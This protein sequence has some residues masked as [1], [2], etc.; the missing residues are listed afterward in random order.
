MIVCFLYK[1]PKEEI[2]KDDDHEQMNMMKTYYSYTVH[3]ILKD[4]TY[5]R[6]VRCNNELGTPI[7]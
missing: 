6:K 7:D 4:K 1:S 2:K 3:Y 5:S